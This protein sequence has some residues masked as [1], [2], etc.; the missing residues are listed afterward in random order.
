MY[1]ACAQKEQNMSAKREVGIKSD[2]GLRLKNVF[3][4]YYRK[5]Q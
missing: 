3:A 4:L 2:T 5:Y 1:I